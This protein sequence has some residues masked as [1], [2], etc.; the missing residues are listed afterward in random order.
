MQNSIEYIKEQRHFKIL[1]IYLIFLLIPYVTLYC[2]IANL[3]NVKL[4]YL[5]ILIYSI[6]ISVV[7][8][9]EFNG[10]VYLFYHL[11]ILIAFQN[12]LA[13]IGMSLFKYQT[14]GANINLLMVYKEVYAIILLLLL[15]IRHLK[16]LK[17][18]SFEKVVPIFIVFILL[19][20]VTSNG[21]TDVKVYYIRSFCVLFLSYFIGRVLFFS[22]KNHQER[23]QNVLYLVVSIGVISVIIGFLFYLIPR[24]YHIWKDWFSLGY[25]MQ[26]KGSEYTDYPDWSTPIG[27]YYIPRMFSFFFDTINLSYFILA[28]IICSMFIKSKWMAFIRI[29]LFT[30]LIFTFGKGAIGILVLVSIWNIFLYR[31]KLRPRLFLTG[32][33]VFIISAFYAITHINF[34]SSM[35]VH[36]NG[37][38][39]PLINSIHNPI[40]SGLGTGGIYYAMKHNILAYDLSFTGTESFFGTLIYQL[41]YPGVILYVLFLIGCIRY[42]L[43]QAYI[44]KKIDY[45]YI[46]LSGVLFAVFI[47]SIFQ[48]QTFGINYTGILIAMAGFY[49]SKIQYDKYKSSLNNPLQ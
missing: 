1:H 12:L 47:I 40:G 35:V 3:H 5:F 49:V 6:A 11:I 46:L 16:N 4:P 9:W 43:K 25:I 10:A 2:L 20:F 22:M 44:G 32:F 34:Y 41:G 33:I 19:N 45:R 15:Y 28:A 39:M 24:T 8:I 26:A 37:F 7:F 27:Q 36:I 38:L 17:F 42:L 29:F 31:I 18:I 23:I 30:G 14:N 13:G 21:E 48:E